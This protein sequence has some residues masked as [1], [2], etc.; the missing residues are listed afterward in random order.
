MLR[1]ISAVFITAMT[2]AAPASAGIGERFENEQPRLHAPQLSDLRVVNGDTA[3]AGD[4]ALLTTISPN[5]D[6]FRDQAVVRFTLSEP[7]TVRLEVYR[8][9]SRAKLP[10][11]V[12]RTVRVLSAG[13]GR[14]RWDPPAHT[15]PRTY[16]I[17]LITTDRD[18]NRRVYGRLV[19]RAVSVPP[20]PVV[21]VQGVDAGF[22]R[23]SY[24]AG[25]HGNLVISTDAHSLTLQFFQ[26]GPEAGAVQAAPGVVGVPI[27][28]PRTI[29]WATNRNRPRGIDV[30]FGSWESGI[31]FLRL[32]AGDGRVGFAPFIVRP[33]AGP[34]SRIAVVVPTNTLQAY[35]HQDVDGDGW[36]DTWYAVNRIPVVDLRRPY[37]NGGLPRGFRATMIG[38]YRWL[39][40]TGKPVQFLSDDD[41]AAYPNGDLLAR[42][43]DLVVFSGHEEYVS[44]HVYDLVTRFRNLG[45]NLMF[46]SANN[47]YWRVRRIDDRIYRAGTWRSLGRPEARLIGVQYISNDGGAHQGSY[48]VMGAQTTPWV[49]AGTGLANGDRFGQGGIEIDAR[50]PYS[51]AGTRL[52]ARMPNLHGPGRSAEMTYYQTPRGSE[53]FAA[54]TV[55]FGMTA[56]RPSVAPILENVWARL[57]VP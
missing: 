25:M 56:L 16:L 41:V 22:T 45:G 23:R 37:V 30:T 21:R 3:F 34:Q 44:T 50:S 53:V 35:N 15:L 13:P 42:R 31:Y 4:R 27:G 46:L 8:A 7:A 47:F 1:R 36:G 14:M 57:S 12:W 33:S 26:L 24:G 49:F 52:L 48:V 2:A 29:G 5:G 20:G 39:Y 54:G 18:G 9:R 6:G 19:R 10:V 38:F 32:T 28:A 55:N 11:R 17:R 43:Y 51:P 40:R